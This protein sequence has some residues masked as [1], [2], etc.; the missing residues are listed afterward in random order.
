MSVVEVQYGCEAPEFRK[1]VVQCVADMTEEERETY[2]KT[3][4]K[5]FQALHE[6]RKKNGYYKRCPKTDWCRLEREK[7][8]TEE[9]QKAEAIR[10]LEA[11]EAVWVEHAKQQEAQSRASLVTIEKLRADVEKLAG[12]VA[13]LLPK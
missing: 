9:K 1:V 8:E 3:Q 5:D 11:R 13:Q 6:E 2:F 12:L 10:L 4:P 7:K